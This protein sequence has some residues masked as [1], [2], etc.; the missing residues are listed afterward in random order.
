MKRL[1]AILLA[2]GLVGTVIGFAATP[3][4]SG[5]DTAGSSWATPVEVTHLLHLPLPL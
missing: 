3:T 2:L 5:P 4:H 1:A